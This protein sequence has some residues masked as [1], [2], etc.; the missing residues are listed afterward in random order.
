MSIPKKVA[1]RLKKQVP[2]FQKILS[3][4]LKRDENE[5]DTVT[6]VC[7]M[8]AGIFG[9]DKY[10]EVTSE[11]Q[12]RGT[13]CD[14]AV[15]VN[16]KTE[17]LIEVK[18]VGIDLKEIHVRQAVAYGASEGIPWIILTNGVKWQV[19]R[20][21]FE[22]P[23]QNDL[24]IEFNFLDMS[25]RAN[26][27]IDTLFLLCKESLKKDKN[28][29]EEFHEYSQVVN[30]YT[31]SA[32][33][34]SEEIVKI[35]RRELRKLVPNLKV[36]TEEVAALI[37]DALKRDTVEGDQAK[38]SEKLLKKA[39]RKVARNRIKE[40]PPEEAPCTDVSA[41]IETVVAETS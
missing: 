10:L 14:L 39:A 3:G 13:Y 21:R 37:Q 40:K 17:F 27:C 36:S 4:A 11:Q 5:S 28:A 23:I 18:A 20:I 22:Q 24:I 8:L 33:I 12:I 41:A 6:I 19:Y 32:I 16:E 34:R 31:V 7:D 38:E 15:V 25:V 9:Y 30:R 35:I 29:I 2:T 26:E 1:E